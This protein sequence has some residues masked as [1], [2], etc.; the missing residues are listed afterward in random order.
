MSA[1]VKRYWSTLS[2][3]HLQSMSKDEIVEAKAVDARLTPEDIHAMQTID[4][5]C[6]DCRHFQRGQMSKGLG[7]ACFEGKCAKTA[8]ATLAWPMQFTG[9]ECF[10]HRRTL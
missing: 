8:A 3:L 4:A 7:V 5:D 9:R 2:P 6:N 1:T 10:E